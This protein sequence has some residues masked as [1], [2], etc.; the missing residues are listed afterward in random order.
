[1]RQSVFDPKQCFVSDQYRSAAVNA[2]NVLKTRSP[3]N[4]PD[5]IIDKMTADY[6]QRLSRVR[7]QA[8]KQFCVA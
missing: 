3:S 4:A 7:L 2:H 1:M 5:G 6:K 8:C